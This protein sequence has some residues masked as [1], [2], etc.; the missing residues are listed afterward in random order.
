MLS[1]LPAQARSV[2]N[3]SLCLNV[4]LFFCLVLYMSSCNEPSPATPSARLNNLLHRK[5]C[6]CI[7]SERDCV[8]RKH[9]KPIIAS[10]CGKPDSL[11]LG[12]KERAGNE[13]GVCARQPKRSLAF[14]GTLS[15]QEI[16]SDWTIDANC[17]ECFSLRPK[18]AVVALVW[19]EFDSLLNAMESWKKNGLIS[20]ADEF[21]IY[22]Q[23]LTPEKRA[24]IEA[25]EGVTVIGTP[26]N[27]NIA[28]ALDT[29]IKT[30]T[31][32]FV[33]FLEKDWVLIEPPNKVKE[34]LEAGMKI[35]MDRKADMVKYRSRWDG[36]HPNF[37]Q[38]FYQGR[39]DDVWKSQPNLL[40]NFYH[41]I[42]D[43]DWRFP[44]KFTRCMDH[45]VFYCIDSYYCNWTNNPIM[46]RKVWWQKHFSKI[47]QSL[48]RNHKHNW[49]GMMNNAQE[50]WNN[51]GYIVAEGNGLFKHVEINESG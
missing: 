25:F 8:E 35:V 47:A 20:Y 49:E 18:L 22:V 37:A 26:N 45:P 3:W 15:P 19:N 11:Y 12:C 44:D 39:E 29:L 31:S 46:F 33:L 2:L 40:C 17:Y 50:V 27:T 28:Y 43:P 42:D 9:C 10:I 48:P 13:T 24:R 30:S 14:Y 51:H 32:D 38:A 16:P 7:T 36:G 34:Q 4:A 21:L 1:R 6:S 5:D 41:W 23:E